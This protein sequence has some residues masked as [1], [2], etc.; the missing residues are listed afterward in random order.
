MWPVLVVTALAAAPTLDL[1]T[2]EDGHALPALVW[3]NAPDLQA[4]R[5]EVARARAEALKA[6]LLP[7]PSLDLSVNTLPVGPLNPVDLPDPFLNVPNVQV[8]LSMLVELGKRGPRQTAANEAARAA[9]LS[10]LEQVRLR[11]LSLQETVGDVAAAEVRVAALEGLAA[12]AERLT[13]LQRA[14]AGAGDTSAL[15]ADRAQLEQEDT[16]TSLAEARE[17]LADA[18]RT[19]AELSGLGC[20]PFADREKAARWLE[21]PIAATSHGL[22]SR[23]DLRALEANAR[24]AE[25][26]A[27]L[28]ARAWLPD[29]TVRVGYVHDRFVVSGNQQ[30]SLFVGLSFPLPIFDRGQAELA[31]ARAEKAAAERARTKLSSNALAQTARLDAQLVNVAARERRLREQSL[32]LAKS[33]VDRLETAVTRGAA[34]LQELLLARRTWAQLVL[35]TNDL[36]RTAMRLQVAKARLTGAGLTPSEDVLDET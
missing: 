32:P 17:S 5:A 23:P 1:S 21:R 25:A 18:L 22:E 10:A 15:D 9:A 11:A 12:D 31:A 6:G 16:Q 24:S 36:D 14:R 4:L 35:T 20:L 26:A 7:N 3:V 29:P 19:C 33:V 2:L 13:A 8:G 34:P 30:N 27:T 28:A